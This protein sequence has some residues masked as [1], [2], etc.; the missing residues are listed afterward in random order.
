MIFIRKFMKSWPKKSH[1]DY[2]QMKIF[3]IRLLPFS[4]CFLQACTSSFE[5]S[6]NELH[7]LSMGRAE[8]AQALARQSRPFAPLVSEER[9]VR[10]TTRSVPLVRSAMLPPHIEQVT[11]RYPGRHSLSTIADVLTRTLGV[12]VLMTPDALQDPLTFRPVNAGMGVNNMAAQANSNT[13]PAGSPSARFT[14]PVASIAGGTMTDTDPSDDIVVRAQQ[15]GA[16]RLGGT[17]LRVSNSFELNYSGSLSGLLDSIASQAQLQWVYE[18]DRI[19]FRR[20]VTQFFQIKTLPGSLKGSSSFSATSG[21]GS[22]SVTSEFGGDL[23]EALKTTLP[24]M[25]SSNGQFLLDTRLGVVTVRD[26]IANVKTVERYVEQVNQ[27]FLRQVNIQVEVIQVD[28]ST[29]AQSGIDWTNLARTLSNGAVLRASGPAFISGTIMPGSVGIFKGDSQALFKSLER[30]GRV[31]NMYSAVVNTMHRQP[32]PLSVTNT[33]T[34]LR[35]VTAGTIGANGTATGPTL[36]VADLTTGFTLSLMPAIL[37]SNL[38][39][40]E[41]ALSISSTRELVQ[42]TT[43]SGFGQTVL[44]QPNVDNF[45]NVQRVTVG[46]GDTVVL[47]GY[48]Y[49]EARNGVTDV[50]RQ[51]LPGSRSS[52]S[53]K[54]TVIILLTPSLGGA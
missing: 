29:D 23:W 4:L 11:V 21:S 34:Y 48:E 18:D 1:P 15:A 22:S 20:V 19:V 7:S 26:A 32:V 12:V 13:Q 8:Q 52:T 36:S 46:L 51:K 40:L 37:D 14:S 41:S 3:L 28:L 16:N 49:E 44:Q 2:R 10:F 24:L 38:V 17:P 25:I 35:S 9:T 53:G 50:V 30:Y 43:G 31:S 47:L 6:N 39:L 27:L 5:K 42:F 33:T 54:K 45:Q